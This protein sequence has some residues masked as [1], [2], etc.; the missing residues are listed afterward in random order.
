MDFYEFLNEL[1]SH[2][3]FSY[4]LLHHY[5]SWFHEIFEYCRD[6]MKSFTNQIFYEVAEM[7]KDFTK[8]L[9]LQSYCNICTMWVEKLSRLNL[10]LQDHS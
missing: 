9:V 1:W 8:S 5:I 10:Y 7:S 4:I 6:L 3:E 2:V